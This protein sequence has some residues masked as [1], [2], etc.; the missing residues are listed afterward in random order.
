[1]LPSLSN[2][3]TAELIALRDRH[4]LRS[5]HALEGPSRVNVTSDGLRLTSFCSNDY[6]GLACHPALARAAAEASARSGFGAAASRLVSGTMPEHLALEDALASLVGAEAALLFPTGYQANLGAITSLAG[7]QDLI[8]ADRANHASIIDACR[9]SRSKLA[10]YR[11]LDLA[12]AE[13]HLTHFGPAARRRFLVTESLFS[14][15]GDVAPLLELLTLARAHDAALIVDEAHAIGCLGPSGGGLCAHFG[16]RP[17]VLVGTLGKAIGASGAFVAGSTGLRDYL[18]NCARTFLFT[19]ALPPPVAAAA[20]AAVRTVTSSDGDL[21]RRALRDRV[22]QLRSLLA[23]PPDPFASPIL[24]WILGPDDHALRAASHLRD[25]G[26]LV[27]AIRPPTVRENTARLRITLSAQHTPEQVA[28]LADAI[29]SL[30]LDLSHPSATAGPHAEPTSTPSLPLSRGPWPPSNDGIFLLGTDTAVGKSTVALALLH[31]LISRGRRPVPFKPVETG[32]DP[33]PSDALRLLAA[34]NRADI[35]LHVVC[36]FSFPSPLP[37]AAAAAAAGLALSIATL[38]SAAAIARSYGTPLV[39]ESA[40]GLL[41]P[42]SDRVTSADLATAL[43]FPVILVS[44]NALGTINHTSLAIAEIRRRAL[45]LAGILLVNTQPCAT[46]DQAFN[47]S[48]IAQLTGDTPLGILPY[49]D[50][51]T[52]DRLAAALEA[53]ADL[54]PILDRLT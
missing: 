28:T 37:A 40:G 18:T 12:R 47:P 25:K 2:Q 29:A 54:R 4:R 26:I 1:M 36:P 30:D 7:P 52:P 53:A 23:L 49:L 34:S 8:V 32:A 38:L 14:M 50:S 33:Q 51:P 27:Q 45:P 5:C 44:R 43:G 19:T 24:P 21:V 31:L 42:Y 39:V 9:L 11:H 16:V 41:S 6:L 20:L 48:L 15:D 22:T 10:F 3:L 46:P 35:P 13:K 17:D